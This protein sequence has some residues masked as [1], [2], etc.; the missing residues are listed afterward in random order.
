MNPDK[1]FHW[2]L[3]GAADTAIFV[4]EPLFAYRIHRNNQNSQQA[5]QGALKHLVD[6]YAA[7]FEFP[8]AMLK[9][10]GLERAQLVSA[11]V[12]RDIVDRGFLLLAAGRRSE[13]RRFARFG[14]ATYPN[15]TLRS[16]RWWALR[17]ALSTG[18][19]GTAAAR[20]ALRLMG[21][22]VSGRDADDASA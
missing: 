14:E 17:S 16:P 15:A 2:R 4:D 21:K 12:E 20:A 13:A 11:F 7:T 5:K 9:K 22:D 19:V 10:A 1:W 18:P 3:L 8:D 6:E